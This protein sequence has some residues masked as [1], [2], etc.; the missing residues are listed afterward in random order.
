M[1]VLGPHG[2]IA[3]LLASPEFV[4]VVALVGI[5]A[6]WLAW[7]Q[8][9]A[10]SLLLSAKVALLV[11]F[12]ALPVALGP[13]ADSDAP[14]ALVTGFAGVAAMLQNAVQRMH[15]ANLAPGTPMT[16][17]TIAPIRG[18]NFDQAAVRSRF[19][20]MLAAIVCFLPV[21]RSRR[22]SARGP[23]SGASRSCTHRRG[24]RRVGCEA[25][26]AARRCSGFRDFDSPRDIFCVTS[27][28]IG[29]ARHSV[30]AETRGMAFAC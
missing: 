28:C 11:A 1:L 22:H 19:N 26:A 24:K 27:L 13:F 4:L 23:D 9:P 12:F 7:R 20:R 15:L 18:T 3:K 30:S 5:A 16:G 17:K 21:A 25:S 29:N 6:D 14:A 8:W 2:A 10:A